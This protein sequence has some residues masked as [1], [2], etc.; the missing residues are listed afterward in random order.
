MQMTTKKRKMA[1]DLNS[2]VTRKDP[3]LSSSSL[4]AIHVHFDHIVESLLKHLQRLEPDAVVGCMYWFTEPQLLQYLAEHKIPTQIIVQKQKLWHRRNSN[5]N[6]EEDDKKP[7]FK[8]KSHYIATKI[9]DAYD[10]L[11]PFAQEKTESKD[12]EA[13]VRCF[14]N[15]VKTGKASNSLLHHK[16]LVLMKETI[17]I[18]VFTGS[19][20]LTA[21]ASDNLENAILIENHKIALQYWQEWNTLLTYSEP[22]DWKTSAM[23][24]T[25]TI[26]ETKP[27]KQSVKQ[28]TFT[29]KPN[30][31]LSF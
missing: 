14:G 18:A 11:T 25:K 23:K 6:N 17:P 27:T 16:F 9:R 21:H 13:A 5:N 29:P 8:S 22:L 3:M 24:G 2:V 15:C 12:N 4:E 20:N 10:A 19:F 30:P 1:M 31:F 28:T 7:S 26:K